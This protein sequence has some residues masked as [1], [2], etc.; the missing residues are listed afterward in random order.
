M[1]IKILKK[2]RLP[3]EVQYHFTCYHCKTEFLATQKDGAYHS[4]QRDGPSLEVACPVCKYKCS[5]WAEYK[6]PELPATLMYSPGCTW[7]E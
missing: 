1:T 3:E 6:E 7:V 2:G 5:S 4:D